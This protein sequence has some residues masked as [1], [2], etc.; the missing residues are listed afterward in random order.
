MK[1]RKLLRML[2]KDGWYIAR[3]RGSHRQLKHLTKKGTVTVSGKPNVDIPQGTFKSI[4]KQA[5]L[6]L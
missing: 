5:K 2:Q 1:V 3:T 6:E 4:L